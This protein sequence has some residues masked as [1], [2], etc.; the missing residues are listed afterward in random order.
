MD[1]CPDCAFCSL[2]REQCQN[3]ESLNRVHCGSGA[4]SPYINPEIAAQ[5]GRIQGQVPS[6]LCLLLLC[7]CTGSWGGGERSMAHFIPPFAVHVLT[8]PE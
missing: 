7:S 4:F 6:Q 5:H 3:I 2:K 1:L 8:D